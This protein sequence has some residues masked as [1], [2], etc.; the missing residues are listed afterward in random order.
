MI[1]GIPHPNLD[2]MPTTRIERLHHK[3]FG[4]WPLRVTLRHAEALIADIVLFLEDM[5][6]EQEPRSCRR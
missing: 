4:R 6:S 5:L 3:V 1:D 2:A